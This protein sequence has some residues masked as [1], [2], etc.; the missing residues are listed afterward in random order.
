MTV[1]EALG[2]IIEMGGVPGAFG[3]GL[4]LVW[5]FLRGKEPKHEDEESEELKALKAIAASMNAMNG[6]LD[7]LL[8]RTQ[9]GDR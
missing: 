6:K 3:S 8:D 1:E 9:R 5:L 7:I 2:K 4:L